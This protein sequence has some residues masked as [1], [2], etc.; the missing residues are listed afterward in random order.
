MCVCFLVFF[1]FII[2]VFIL[3]PQY[4]FFLLYLMVSQ[5][6]IHV[7]VCV[8]FLLFRAAPTEYGG[9]QARSLIGAVAAG[10]HHSH[11]NARSELCL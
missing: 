10:L 7:Y 9:S 1:N 4:I 3:F 11:S 6:H 2:Y 5:L 8:C